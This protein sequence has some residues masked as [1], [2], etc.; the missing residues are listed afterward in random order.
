MLTACQESNRCPR[1]IGGLCGCVRR[2]L[3]KGYTPSGCPKGGRDCES[4]A[5]GGRCNKDNLRPE[6]T[7]R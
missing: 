5:C 1:Y 3:E 6:E 4:P 7:K 2:A